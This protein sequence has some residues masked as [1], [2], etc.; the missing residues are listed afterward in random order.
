MMM[1]TP[2]MVLAMAGMLSA[3]ADQLPQIDEQPW[4]GCWIVN[5]QPQFDYSISAHD[6]KAGLFPKVRKNAEYVRAGVHDRFEF[7]FI[8]RSW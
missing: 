4:L 5:D 1:K 6:G 8:L 2:M 3:S 7:V